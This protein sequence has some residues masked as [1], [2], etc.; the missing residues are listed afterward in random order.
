MSRVLKQLAAGVLTLFVL[1]VLVVT[2]VVAQGNNSSLSK[3]LTTL[4]TDD[5]I[6]QLS[7]LDFE[8]KRTARSLS[9][10]K[11]TK[12]EDTDFDRTVH[13]V[14]LET[15]QFDV[16]QSGEVVSAFNYADL[17]DED[18]GVIG[19]D[20]EDL[21]AYTATKADVIAL[22]KEIVK[23]YNLEDY[24]LVECTNEIPVVWILTWNKRLTENVLNPYDVMTVTVDAKDC[25]V[26]L[27]RRNTVIP[28]ETLPLIDEKEAILKTQEIQELMGDPG[29]DSAVL[30]VFRPNYYWEFPETIQEAD[31][32]RL[33]WCIKL[34]DVAVVYVDARS[35]EI[36]GGSITRSVVY[37]RAVCAVPDFD[38]ADICVELAYLGINRLGYTHHLNTVNY[39]ISQADIEYVLNDSNLKALYL[40]CHGG[41]DLLGRRYI[42]D[43]VKSGWKI[44]PKDIENSDY[45]FVFLDACN[46]SV[47]DKFANAFLGSDRT[48]KCF[49]GWNLSVYV[50]TAN[51]FNSHFWPRVGTMTILDAVLI[52]RENSIGQGFSDCNPGFSGDVDY[53][54]E[55]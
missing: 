23:E 9:T 12:V 54:G 34:A 33:A 11:V 53:N 55:P 26:M 48:G 36:L 15:F 27:M 52:A 46:T 47:T 49:I 10:A 18:V 30:T 50:E 37:A 29:V 25:S 51:Y 28:D 1:L 38:G 16:D 41:I 14:E 2:P 43:G 8:V 31:F 42:T 13:R 7:V 39:Y 40:S 21:S 19:G 35:G 22:S 20:T 5:V 44:Y 4:M 24:E 6:D 45:S 32:V 17:H 3:S